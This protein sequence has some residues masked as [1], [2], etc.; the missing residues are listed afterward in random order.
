MTEQGEVMM[1]Y[2]T[3]AKRQLQATQI[4]MESEQ[5]RVDITGD[6][7]L[8]AVSVARAARD[9]AEATAAAL[10]DLNVAKTMW[11][12]T[13]RTDDTALGGSGCWGDGVNDARLEYRRYQVDADGNKLTGSETAWTLA[14]I[15]QV[16]TLQDD[17]RTL[18]DA[19]D[20]FLVNADPDGGNKVRKS[21]KD[22]SS[23]LGG[24]FPEEN[25]QGARGRVDRVAV[26]HRLAF[27]PVASSPNWQTEVR[28]VNYAY[29]TV[30]AKA[31][32]HYLLFG[33]TMNTSLSFTKPALDY[34][35][36]PMYTKLVT[37][38][39]GS[40]EEDSVKQRC[41]ATSVEATKRSIKEI[42][43]E[44]MA[45]SLAAA[46]AGKGTQV[47][48]GPKNLPGTSS[49]AWHIAV[50]IQPP[51]PPKP[52]IGKRLMRGLSAPPVDDEYDAPR[53]RGANGGAAMSDDDDEPMAYR[54]CSA[55]GD[56]SSSSPSSVSAG[57]RVADGAPLP[58]KDAKEARIGLGTW[59]CDATPNTITTPIAK[60]I[61]AT[62]TA[63]YIMAIPIGT[64]PSMESMIDAGIFLKERHAL[65]NNVGTEIE[66]RCSQQAVDAGMTSAG[67]LSKK[68]KLDIETSVGHGIF[69]PGSKNDAPKIATGRPLLTGMPIG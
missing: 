55:P 50:A 48:T 51:P 28:Y 47:R 30:D 3:Q 57:D 29:N 21:L 5:E 49:C 19:D 1:G 46:A 44:T 61:P 45:E 52:V 37:S 4:T 15:V 65:S 63:V 41:F 60:P 32:G 10:A 14:Q 31:P 67:P 13:Q 59:V 2:L 26:G 22:L 36:A 38:I 11:C 24:N 58:R 16:G 64:V 25:L 56:A 8:H 20:F 54:S 42:G 40:G 17:T 43:T 39:N 34:G 6:E 9:K 7:K 23:N 62:A 69:A 35:F 68:A 18:M 53:Y 12:D 66:K 33:D 27:V